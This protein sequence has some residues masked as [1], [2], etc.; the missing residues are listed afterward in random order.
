M[1]IDPGKPPALPKGKVGLMSKPVNQLVVFY[2]PRGGLKRRGAM[3][4]APAPLLHR[5]PTPPC[6]HR[7]DICNCE[8]CELG[9]RCTCYLC[10]GKHEA[11]DHTLF[12]QFVCVPCGRSAK[13]AL[14]AAWLAERA[15]TEQR[16]LQKEQ[17]PAGD[18][19]P[20]PAP[21]RSA[22]ER[23]DDPRTACEHEDSTPSRFLNEERPKACGGCGQP[24]HMVGPSFQT[25]KQSDKKA[26]RRV[27]KL[28]DAGYLF[29]ACPCVKER[30]A[31]ALAALG[32][33]HASEVR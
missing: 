24:M 33:E 17:N 27:Q 16:E 4:E 5:P 10:R 7:G 6:A 3:A 28:I 26:W 31:R 12:R 30:N 25:P 21:G 29:S 22:V 23:L 8:Y 2:R 14:P 13:N 20:G 19:G 18:R 9:C 1:L 11:S 15:R 32:V